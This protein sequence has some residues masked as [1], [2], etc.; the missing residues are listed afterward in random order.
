MKKLLKLGIILSIVI[1]VL[2]AVSYFF[3]VPKIVSSP[4]FIEFIQNNVKK[5]LGANLILDKPVLLTSPKLLVDFKAKSVVLE[6]DGETLLSAE[7]LHCNLSLKKILLKQIILNKFGA[8][9][10][11]ADVNQ[12]QT[13][14]L[15]EQKE[16]KPYIKLMMFL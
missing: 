16:S 10:V 14:S 5:S 7:N 4:E 13:I 8:D 15:K 6:K 3:I 11:F 2:V 12:L 1:T 9:D